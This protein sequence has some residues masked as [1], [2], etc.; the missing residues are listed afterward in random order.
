MSA[1]SRNS[2]IQENPSMNTDNIFDEESTSTPSAH[3]S[4]PGE[5]AVALPSTPPL[6]EVQPTSSLLTESHQS[7]TTQA[8]NVRILSYGHS[9]RFIPG[10]I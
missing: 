5:S 7:T 10:K 3:V 6:S 4:V 9:V 8:D 1:A 2:I